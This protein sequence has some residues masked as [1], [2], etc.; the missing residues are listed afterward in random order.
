MDVLECP[1]VTEVRPWISPALGALA[2]PGR[3]S[4]TQDSSSPNT[5][6][7]QAN[8]GVGIVYGVLVCRTR[9]RN[10]LFPW[11]SACR[12]RGLLVDVD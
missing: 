3:A 5:S 6:L 11:F 4:H 12:H 7:R 1:K 9:G 2:P 8:A 10:I